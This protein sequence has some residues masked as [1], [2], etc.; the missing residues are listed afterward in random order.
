MKPSKFG[1]FNKNGRNMVV[2]KSRNNKNKNRNMVYVID[3][4]HT[5]A[6]VV[7]SS[8][9]V[10]L[11]MQHSS[12]TSPRRFDYH[13][14]I[15]IGKKN[16]ET[17][18]ATMKA[19]DLGDLI[20]NEE[21][22]PIQ[23]TSPGELD[24]YLLNE[25]ESHPVEDWNRDRD[26][27]RG[28]MLKVKPQFFNGY[29]F[30]SYDNPTVDDVEHA[31]DLFDSF[32]P[33]RK[34]LVETYLKKIEHEHEALKRAHSLEI[35]TVT[36]NWKTEKSRYEQS[37]ENYRRAR[38]DYNKKKITFNEI[39]SQ[40]FS[41]GI[42]QDVIEH[43]EKEDFKK[44]L[45]ALQSV[46]F[47]ATREDGNLLMRVINDTTYYSHMDFPLFKRAM[48]FI[49]EMLSNCHGYVMDDALKKRKKNP[50]IAAI[51][52]DLKKLFASWR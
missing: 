43:L 25:V 22:E 18:V 11:I 51:M 15:V 33:M 42:I 10:P 47:S 16:Y 1:K 17:M 23:P 6:S 31:R 12:M 36:Q 14:H 30:Q 52:K 27:V 37:T 21:I 49:F 5:G 32:P 46:V 26:L 41:N 9:V 29:V 7:A 44:T 8:D 3:G 50:S 35:S 13:G 20:K 34:N 38:G 45:E 28:I 48:D 24:D 2:E 39:M 40:F 19:N 4:A